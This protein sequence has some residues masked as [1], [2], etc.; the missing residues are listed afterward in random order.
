MVRVAAAGVVFARVTRLVERLEMLA[1]VFVVVVV[2]VDQLVLKLGGF[3]LGEVSV[4]DAENTLRVVGC[5]HQI[6]RHHE[7]REFQLVIEP[8]QKLVKRVGVLNV[9]PRRR[10]VEDQQFR[11]VRKRPGDEDPLELTTGKLTE[12]GRPERFHPDQAQNVPDPLAVNAF[13]PVEKADLRELVREKHFLDRGGEVR[14]HVRMPL[15]HVPDPGPAAER[16]HVLAEKPNLAGLGLELVEEELQER[17]FPGPVGADDDREIP[18]VH[19][20]RN[21]VEERHFTA[22]R[23]S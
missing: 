20:E 9:D 3:H 10:L 23:K 21:I 17:A 12:A 1:A 13:H 15:R 11:P 6:V 22:P 2:M 7:D 18:G 19:L 16:A 4:L 8:V 5:V 14:I